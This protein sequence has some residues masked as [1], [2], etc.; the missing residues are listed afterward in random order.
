MGQRFDGGID[1]GNGRGTNAASPTADTDVVNKA[2]ADAIAQGLSWKNAARAASTANIDLSSPGTTVDGVTLANGDRFLA[3][4]QTAGAENGLYVFNGA[5]SAATRATD[6][7]T[8]A[9]I[10]GAAVFV[11][12]GSVNAD[13]RFNLTT[14]GV[15]LGTTALTFSPFGDGSVTYTAGNGAISIS[16]AAISGVAVSGGGILIGGSGFYVDTSKV[17]QRYDTT[18]GDGSTTA[19]TITHNLGTKRVSVTVIDTAADHETVIIP[20]TRPTINT[21]AMT[22]ASAPSSNQYVVR[23]ES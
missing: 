13:K 4:N 18:I 5:S 16:G 6:A 9:K 22:F 23:V 21:V 14:D 17:A 11:T 3:K 20:A 1:L 8:A 15:T 7:N 19:F 2:Y 10:K 12:E